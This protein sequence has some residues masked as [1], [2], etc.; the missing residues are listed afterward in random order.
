MTQQFMPKIFHGPC[1]SSPNPS[2]M[3]Q[4]NSVKWAHTK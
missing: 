4:L 1:K 2:T 3:L